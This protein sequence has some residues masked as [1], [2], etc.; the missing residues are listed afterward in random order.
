MTINPYEAPSAN[1]DE[2]IDNNAPP[3]WNPTAAANWCLL[4]SVAF[5]SYLH[6]KNW[7]ALGEQDKAASS[8]VWFGISVFL[9]LSTLFLSPH[10]PK[11]YALSQISLFVLLLVWYFASAK[12]QMR[13]VKE[14]FGDNYPRKGWL[15]PIGLA[16]I[17]IFACS[18]VASFV[19]LLLFPR[20]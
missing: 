10:A 20:P 13:Y 8:K 4:L 14:R 9:M 15:K 11:L 16:L 12:A 7:E 1:L 19:N 5:G 3:L 6:M 18:L 2:P 17:S